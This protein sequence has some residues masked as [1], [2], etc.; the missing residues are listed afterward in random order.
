[1][2]QVVSLQS[3]DPGAFFN[4]LLAEPRAGIVVLANAKRKA[5]YT[6]QLSGASGLELC[7]C[8]VRRV[9]PSDDLDATLA[10]L[11][12]L[13]LLLLPVKLP[14]HAAWRHQRGQPGRFRLLHRVCGHNA[15]AQLGGGLRA[16]APGRRPAG[17]SYIALA[18]KLLGGLADST[19]CSAQTLDCRRT[20]CPHH[21][22]VAT[23]PGPAAV[24][25]ACAFAAAPQA[26]ALFVVQ[27]TAIQQYGL[28]AA[29]RRSDT[30]AAAPA[31]QQQAAPQ[32][33]PPKAALSPA[34]SA[35]SIGGL[36]REQFVVLQSALLRIGTLC[37]VGANSCQRS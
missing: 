22:C 6:L 32:P 14:D 15:G 25:Q 36:Q 26:V 3:S 31:P 11:S 35:H 18:L 16:A 20:Q 8:M 1:M 33:Q 19:T 9:A 37:W 5:V 29:L 30:A 12:R 7:W 34:S 24:S 4:H 13:S 27:P 2:D 10:A 28:A 23:T 21:P 17:N